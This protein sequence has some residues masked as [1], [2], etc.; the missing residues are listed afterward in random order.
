L[1]HLSVPTIFVFV[2]KRSIPYYI[3][4]QRLYFKRDDIETWVNAGRRMTVDEIREAAKES[5]V[6]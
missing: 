3:R 4:G 6:V 1:L 5:L 2:H